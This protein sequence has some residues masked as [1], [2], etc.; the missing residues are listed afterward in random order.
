MMKKNILF[1]ALF[2]TLCGFAYSQHSDLIAKGIN[3]EQ[4]GLLDRAKGYYEQ[5]AAAEPDNAEPLLMLGKLQEKR[6]HFSE[7]AVTLRQAVALNDTLA[8]A[9]EH[10]V[11]CYI[12]NGD[13][14][15]SRSGHFNGVDDLQQLAERAIELNPQSTSAYCS[16]ALIYNYRKNYTN[17]INWV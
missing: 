14:D 10:L 3:A 11:Y 4:L 1:I 6:S 9:Y 13:F 16:M 12:E 5:V 8:E 17:A 15:G 2:S 7:A